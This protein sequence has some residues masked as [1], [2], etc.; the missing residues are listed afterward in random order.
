[1]PEGIIVKNEIIASGLAVLN[2]KLQ[3]SMNQFQEGEK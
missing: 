3:N 1:V 2:T